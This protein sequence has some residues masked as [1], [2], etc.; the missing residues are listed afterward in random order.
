MISFPNAKINIGLN[1][2]SKRSDGFHNIETIFYPIE[3]SDIVEFI[4]S[5]ETTLEISGIDINGNFKN[6]LVYKAYDL[7][8]NDFNLPEIKIHL[9]KIIPTEAGLGGGS[10]DA[11]FMLKA[12]NEHFSLN[13]PDKKL[14]KYAEQLGSD[15]PFFIK[16]KPAYATNKGEKLEKLDFSLKGY[17]IV[18]I[19]PNVQ[20]STAEA[21]QNIKLAE[22]NLDLKEAVK[23]PIDEWKDNIF[24]NFEDYAFA[25][26]PELKEIKTYLYN[27]GAEFALMT[28]SGSAIYGI[29]KEKPEINKYKECFAWVGKIN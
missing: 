23:L 22:P 9:H 1:V 7:L 19:K 20:I 18:L 5:N 14:L 26:Y 6:N 11:S 15:C 2:T 10:A 21:Y 4:P 29:F 12:L 8:K 17:S 28:G 25:K 16:N 3:L 13:I 24:N 27:I